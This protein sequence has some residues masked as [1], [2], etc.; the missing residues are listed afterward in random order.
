MIKWRIGHLQNFSFKKS[1]PLQNKK[2]HSSW[3]FSLF[4]VLILIS[5]V[6]C[7]SY[8]PQSKCCLNPSVV[9]SARMLIMQHFQVC[10]MHV[11][12]CGSILQLCCVLY[13]YKGRNN[14]TQGSDTPKNVS[15]WRFW[16][17]L[18]LLVWG[19]DWWLRRLRP[20]ER[21]VEELF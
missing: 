17:R 3:K 16:Q 20:P 10:L 9:D 2:E 6:A 13:W 14:S 4:S 7:V 5:L 21:W 15:P 1:C 18:Q 19:G 11:Y 12:S 8:S